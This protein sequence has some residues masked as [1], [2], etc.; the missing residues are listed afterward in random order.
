[1]EGNQEYLPQGLEGQTFYRPKTIGRE[2]EIAH[3]LKNKWGNK[4]GYN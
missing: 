4:Y 2:A 3:F 1:L